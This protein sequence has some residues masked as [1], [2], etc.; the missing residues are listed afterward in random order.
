MADSVRHYYEKD[1]LM[2]HYFHTGMAEGKWNH[3]MAQTRIGYTYWQQPEFNVVPKTERVSVLSGAQP[4]MQ[5]EGHGA[6]Y[7]SE[8]DRLPEFDVF[9]Q[10]S[11][12]LELFNKGD[13]SFKYRLTS[14]QKWVKFSSAKGSIDDQK[15]IYV[16]IDWDQAPVGLNEAVVNVK[17][18]KR[19][20]DVKLSAWNP[21]EAQKAAISGF[22]E[23]R[24]YVSM[25][26]SNYSRVNET[27]AI[28]WLVIPDIGRTLDGMVAQPY[29]VEEQV[30]GEGP[31]IEYELYLRTPG[32][33]KVH[34]YF[35][36][37]L[38]YPGGE[39]LHYGISFDDDAPVVINAHA[40]ASDNAW[41]Q[42]VGNS[43]MVHTSEH[44][45]ESAGQHT[46]KYHMVSP[47]LVL[48][49]IVVDT[50]GLKNTY[51]GPEESFKK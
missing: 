31:S 50:G 4:D 43:I 47:G 40:D 25:E 13:Q 15:R 7:S 49:K 2:T 48:Q 26:S 28:S 46:L 38:N 41:Y 19:S 21:S 18:G 20:M 34:A 24:G 35:S 51:L 22:V 39:G 23:T 10:P 30:A 6:V 1:S 16:S 29:R 17:A 42:K 12:Y 3:M 8:S 44:S 27:D 32:T 36:P 14:K 33:V 5:V 11:Y 37:T 9:N 45:I